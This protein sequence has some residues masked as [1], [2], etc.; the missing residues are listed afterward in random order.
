MYIFRF[1]CYAHRYTQ[2]TTA[3]HLPCELWIRN[4]LFVSFQYVQYDINI[5]IYLCVCVWVSIRCIKRIDL[6]RN[7]CYKIGLWLLMRT[8]RFILTTWIR[9]QFILQQMRPKSTNEQIRRQKK[10]KK[11]QTQRFNF[12]FFCIVD[13]SPFLHLAHVA[14]NE[15]RQNG[16]CAIVKRANANIIIK[17]TKTWINAFLQWIVWASYTEHQR[18]IMPTNGKN[19]KMKKTLAVIPC[20]VTT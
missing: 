4:K 5:N 3:I 17:K 8:I 1:E 2:N 14:S 13:R 15:Y 6:W 12:Q 16:E 20:Q 19:I 18:A 7:V 9:L 11:K 10:K